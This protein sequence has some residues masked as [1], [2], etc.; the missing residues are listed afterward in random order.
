MLEKQLDNLR[1]R[2]TVVN[3]VDIVKAYGKC[4]VFS[5]QLFK[6]VMAEVIDEGN[7]KLIVDVKDLDCIDSSGLV[8]VL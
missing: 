8:A 6:D 4:D 7:T 5:V 1:V 3:S 2:R